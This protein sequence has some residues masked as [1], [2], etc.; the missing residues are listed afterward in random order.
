MGCM[1][2]FT[3]ATKALALLALTFEEFNMEMMYYLGK[4]WLKKE[5]NNLPS[6]AT[7]K[8]EKNSNIFNKQCIISWQTF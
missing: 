5:M 2:E 1:K 8:E 7:I 4:L 6:W 3:H